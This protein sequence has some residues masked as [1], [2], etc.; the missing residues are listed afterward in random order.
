[1]VA[2]QR[3]FYSDCSRTGIA[4]VDDGLVYIPLEQ[5][6]KLCMDGELKRITALHLKFRRII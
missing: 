1:M 3:F 5:A 4:R 2:T 6:Q